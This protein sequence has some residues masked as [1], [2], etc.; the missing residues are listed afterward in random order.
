MKKTIKLFLLLSLSSFFPLFLNAEEVISRFIQGGLP[1]EPSDRKWQKAKGVDVLMAPQAFV[2]PGIK[3]PSVPRAKVFSLHNGSEIA[4]LLQWH[5]P[6]KDEATNMPDR[7]SDACAIQFPAEEGDTPPNFMM[8]EKGKPVHIILWKA[9][10]EKDIREGYQDV[11]HAYPN[12]Y[13][14]GYPMAKTRENKPLYPVKDLPEE[15]KK[16]LPGIAVGNPLSDLTRKTPFEELIAE[17]FGTITTQKH[18]DVTGKGIWK[19]S[20]WKVV[21]KRKLNT[22][23]PFDSVL[24]QGENFFSI[25]IWDGEKKQAG[26][27][28]NYSAAGWL[29]LRIE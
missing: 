6:T 2:K 14:D 4:F 17:G 12:Y 27:R 10:W 16:F 11:E 15:A 1:T 19:N 25:A 22:G 13:V 26:S 5:D 7:F 9:V 3:E 21:I 24:K 20:Y 28:K 29:T 23:D 8:G 18:F